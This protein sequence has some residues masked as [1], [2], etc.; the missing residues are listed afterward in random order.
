MPAQELPSAALSRYAD[1]LQGPQPEMV[2]AS[3][4]DGNT[5]AQLWAVAQP[6]AR[7]L[8]LLWDKGNNVF[9]LAG[10]PQSDGARHELAQLIRGPLRLRALS[11]GLGRFKVC[12]L[13]PALGRAL[14]EL[15][16]GC[17]LRAC[18]EHFLRFEQQQPPSVPAPEMVRLVSIDRALLA[19]DDLDQIAQLRDEI[20]WM[21]PSQDQFERYGFGSAALVERAIVCWCTAEYVSGSA[22]G[23]G[24][25]TEPD[26]EGRGVATATAAHFVA[27]SLRRGLRPH[28]QCA[29]GNPASLRVAE[30]LGFRLLESPQFWIGNFAG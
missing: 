26:Y 15:F 18:D 20:A 25:A 3:A 4:L 14:P 7:D 21:W 9:Y 1:L 24:I 29:A 28:W 12:A 10:V 30:K 17:G 11:E 6:D 27:E 19:R 2:V 13:T 22:C 8:L 23:I 5:A 16:A